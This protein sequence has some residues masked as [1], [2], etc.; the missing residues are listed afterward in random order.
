MPGIAQ[1]NLT[2]THLLG[3]I[4]TKDQFDQM[5]K[6][7]APRITIALHLVRNLGGG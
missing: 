4:A 7:I 3:Q 6:F 2:P 5:P 1:N